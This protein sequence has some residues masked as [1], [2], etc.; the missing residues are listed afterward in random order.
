MSNDRQWMA[1]KGYEGIYEVSNQGHVRRIHYYNGRNGPADVSCGTKEHWQTWSLR[2]MTVRL[3]RYGKA[4]TYRVHWLVAEHFLPRPPTADV[5]I[6]KNYEVDDNRVC[7]LKWCTRE[8]AREHKK[9]QA[10]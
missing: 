6:H 2:G 8:E 3:F 1:I 7:N 4:K 10:T 5:V 9:R